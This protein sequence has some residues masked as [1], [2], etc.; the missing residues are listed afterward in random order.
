MHEV[1]RAEVVGLRELLRLFGR[2]G[3]LCVAHRLRLTARCLDFMLIFVKNNH[4][5]I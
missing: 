2:L 4:E 3:R 5:Y 1:K